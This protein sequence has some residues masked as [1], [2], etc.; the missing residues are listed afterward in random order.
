MMSQAHAANKFCRHALPARSPLRLRVHC[1]PSYLYGARIVVIISP[2]N[3]RTQVCRLSELSIIIAC[4][5]LMCLIPLYSCVGRGQIVQ[6]ILATP[7]GVAAAGLVA[8]FFGGLVNVWSSVIPAFFLAVCLGWCAMQ[9]GSTESHD[10]KSCK[11]KPRPLT[12]GVLV[13]RGSLVAFLRGVP[14][15]VFARRFRPRVFA[16][17]YLLT[18]LLAVS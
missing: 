11:T 16:S 13:Q 7:F 9:C 12:T 8:M 18:L 17:R 6:P 14:N 10:M 1:P 15:L 5:I 4:L 2:N 3:N